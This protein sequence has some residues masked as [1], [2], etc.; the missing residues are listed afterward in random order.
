MPHP[1]FPVLFPFQISPCRVGS[2]QYTR[3]IPH[4]H[5]RQRKSGYRIAACRKRNP[6]RFFLLFPLQISKE[7]IYHQH[8][9]RHFLPCRL[10]HV[11]SK[12]GKQCATDDTAFPLLAPLPQGTGYGKEKQGVKRRPGYSLFHQQPCQRVRRHRS[13]RFR[14]VLPCHGI[15]RIHIIAV[16][17]PLQRAFFEHRPSSFRTLYPAFCALLLRNGTVH[18]QGS[19][20]L[21]RTT[22]RN[23]CQCSQRRKE[24]T[25]FVRLMHYRHTANKKNARSD[26]SSTGKGQKDSCKSQDY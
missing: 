7:Q 14:A 5:S 13:E 10:A 8:E 26:V 3:N 15:E 11:L 18:R 25:E 12:Q 22:H 16:A 2:S 19:P 23:Q 9:E 1:S 4:Q 6:F 17:V 20:K 21:F 24:N